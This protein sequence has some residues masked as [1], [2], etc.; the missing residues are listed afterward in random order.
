LRIVQPV[1]PD[2]TTTAQFDIV[3]ISGTEIVV[4]PLAS[5]N[6]ADMRKRSAVG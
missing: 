1:N 2:P 3:S 5:R 6:L 4:A